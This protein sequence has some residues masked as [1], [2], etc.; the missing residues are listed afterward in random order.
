MCYVQSFIDIKTISGRGIKGNSPNTYKGN[1]NRMFKYFNSKFGIEDNDEIVRTLSPLD[2]DELKVWMI[3]NEYAVSTING[4]LGTAKQ[5]SLFL[6]SRNIIEKDFMS[7]VELI[8]ENN[9]YKNLKKKKVKDQMEKEDINALIKSCLTRYDGE[10]DYEFNSVRNIFIM[11]LCMSTGMRVGEAVSIKF[12]QMYLTDGNELYVH[13]TEEQ[14]K[15]RIAKD[16]CI[17]G[18]A[19]KYFNKY[20]EMRKNIKYE[21]VDKDYLILSAKGKKFNE[22]NVNDFLLKY[23]KRIDGNKHFSSHCFRYLFTNTGNV[24]CRE[25]IVLINKIG[26][27]SNKGL[28]QFHYAEAGITEKDILRCC[29]SVQEYLIDKRYYK[30]TSFLDVVNNY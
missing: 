23:E 7:G 3:K 4:T 13:F 2:M 11:L 20:I 12:D 15:C 8:S 26:G 27:W 29:L 6:L 28:M 18:Y 16:I 1:L 24:D 21:I 25:S 22:K 5:L 19:L 9:Q 17:C 14:T 30:G 10:R